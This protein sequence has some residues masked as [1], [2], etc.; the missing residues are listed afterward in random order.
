MVDVI[1]IYK[2]LAA[3]RIET[4]VIR[5]G[6]EYGVVRMNCVVFISVYCFSQPVRHSFHLEYF[7]SSD[8]Y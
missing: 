5:F 7:Y 2:F 8:I 1:F 3:I 6:S 4:S